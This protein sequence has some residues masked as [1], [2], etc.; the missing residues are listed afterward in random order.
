MFEKI[1]VFAE[2]LAASAGQS[3]R[4]FL[5]RLGKLA[6]GAAGVAGALLHQL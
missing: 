6:I 3:R 5:G 1:E 2:T 4:G